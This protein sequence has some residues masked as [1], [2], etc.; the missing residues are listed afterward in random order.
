MA[1]LRDNP[2]LRELI[3]TWSAWCHAENRRDVEV[4]E[5]LVP[6]RTLERYDL[7]GYMST[8]FPNW[9]DDISS[10]LPYLTSICLYNLSACDSLPPLGRLPNLRSLRLALGA[11]TTSGKSAR[12]FMERKEPAKS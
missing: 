10:C 5:N 3:L 8:N 11:F 4:L 7:R 9:M 1:K 12:N 2:D 6:P